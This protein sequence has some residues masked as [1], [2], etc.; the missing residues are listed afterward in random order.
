MKI[1]DK[2]RQLLN[3]YVYKLVNLITDWGGAWGGE[4]RGGGFLTYAVYYKLEGLITDWGGGWG[5]G[6]PGVGGFLTYAVYK[7]EGLITSGG[8]FF[9]ALVSRLSTG[10]HR[11]W[12]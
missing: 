2:N 7:L 9:W 12:V 3:Q 8:G 10:Q 5:W 11:P 4:G 1:S 6:G